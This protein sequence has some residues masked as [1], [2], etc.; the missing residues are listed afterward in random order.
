MDPALQQE[1]IVRHYRRPRNR[2]RIDEPT[3]TGEAT[4]PFC[5]DEVTLDLVVRDGRVDE[6]LFDGRGCTIS[7]ASASMLTSRLEGKTLDEVRDLMDRFARYLRGEEGAS[8]EGLGELV[9]LQGV[10]RFPTRIRCALLPFDA[11]REALGEDAS[12]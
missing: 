5:G 4:N 2:G 12:A 6:A 9:A 11:L 1:L 8:E 3:G 10:A 7:Q